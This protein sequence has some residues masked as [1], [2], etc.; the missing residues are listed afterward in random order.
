MFLYLINIIL[1]F[2]SASGHQK[3]GQ[4][5]HRGPR[6][7]PLA[8]VRQESAQQRPGG[9]NRFVGAGEWRRN[10]WGGAG[11]A[12]QWNEIQHARLRRRLESRSAELVWPEPHQR[13]QSFQPFRQRLRI[14]RSQGEMSHLAA[15]AR[16][17]AVGVVMGPGDRQRRC[18]VRH[19]ADAGLK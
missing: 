2:C 3:T 10:G 6:G 8:I 16:S 14:V 9:L 11:S 1:E 19:R 15:G 4:V 18:S 7:Q 13:Q 17:L 12:R 5:W